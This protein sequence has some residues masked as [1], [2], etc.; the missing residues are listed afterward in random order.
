MRKNEFTVSSMVVKVIV[1][2]YVFIKLYN[3]TPFIFHKKC[4]WE[5]VCKLYITNSSFFSKL[6]F[7][8]DMQTVLEF[9]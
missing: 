9:T 2:V 5:Q 1:T 6:C 7:H 3:Y 8:T 4:V